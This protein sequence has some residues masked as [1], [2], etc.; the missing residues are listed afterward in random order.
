MKIFG[1]DIRRQ[2]KTAGGEDIDVILRRLHAFYDTVSGIRVTPES[3]MQSPTVSALVTGVSRRMSTMPVQVI[4]KTI[5]KG[6]ESREILPDHSV[7]KLLR[8]PNPWQTRMNYWSDATSVIMRHGNYVAHKGQGKTGPIRRLVPFQPTCIGVHQDE[9]TLDHY[10]LYNGIRY[11]WWEV[12]HARGPARDFMWGD[13]P[14]MNVRETIALEIAAEKFGAAFFGNGALPFVVF[15]FNEAIKKGF[16]DDADREEFINQFQEAY[17]QGRQFRAFALPAGMDMSSPI[18]VSNDKAQ[19]IETR[20][21]Q[22]NV[23]AGAWGI[24]PHV[25]G[26][27]ERA[28]FNNVEQLGLELQMAV[29][30]PQA[31]TFEAAMERDLLSDADRKEGICIR[32]NMDAVLRGDFKARQEGNKIQREGGVLTI[33]EWREREGMNPIEEE[34][35]DKCIMPSNF[36]FTDAPPPDPAAARPFGKPAVGKPAV[37]NEDEEPEEEPVDDPKGLDFW[38]QMRL[39]INKA[40]EINLKG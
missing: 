25:A 32:F 5:K 23:I 7:A 20:K 17:T 16:K 14:V 28:T 4:K 22:R 39:D 33:N 29:I 2:Q 15:K 34:W 27:L 24:P 36:V 18:D 38:E 3:C 9:G 12:T 11:E 10:Y 8:A 35:A 26:D 21:H 30:L 1:L 19:F 37:E 40:R 31:M 6:R 13:S